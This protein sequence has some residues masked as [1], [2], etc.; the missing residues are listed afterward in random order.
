[1]KQRF[2][3]CESNLQAKIYHVHSSIRCHNSLVTVVNFY[4]IDPTWVLFPTK[5]MAS[6]LLFS[7][8]LSK[9]QQ[10]IF[11]SEWIGWGIKLTPVSLYWQ[12]EAIQQIS[13]S[14]SMALCIHKHKDCFPFCFQIILSVVPLDMYKNCFSTKFIQNIKEKKY[15]LEQ[16]NTAFN[17]S[18]FLK[19]AVRV[20]F[21]NCFVQLWMTNS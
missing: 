16:N 12:Y 1:M 14:I 11:P 18:L 5:A 9:R 6:R 8:P 7:Q 3:A 17:I 13:P 19:H 10:G 20:W 21:W 2:H 15:R 4:G